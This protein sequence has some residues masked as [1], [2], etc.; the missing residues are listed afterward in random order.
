MTIKDYIIYV[1]FNVSLYMSFVIN[2]L[3]CWTHYFRVYT[4]YTS[5]EVKQER[6]QRRRRGGGAWE[7]PPPLTKMS[8]YASENVHI[9]QEQSKEPLRFKFKR[10]L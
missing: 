4:L 1:E 5:Y 6:I 8:G 7:R 10:S 3:P 2:I 9:W